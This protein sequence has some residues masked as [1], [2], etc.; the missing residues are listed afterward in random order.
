MAQAVELGCRAH[1]LGEADLCPIICNGSNRLANAG[2]RLT[3]AAQNAMMVLSYR[4][5]GREGIG[6]G[7]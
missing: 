1:W 4:P 6:A 7:R 3:Q 2:L 5:V